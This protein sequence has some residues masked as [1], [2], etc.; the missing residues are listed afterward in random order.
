MR[1]CTVD[2]ITFN[3]V[4]DPDGHPYVIEG[5][6]KNALKIFFE[7]EESRREYLGVTVECPGKDFQYNLNNPT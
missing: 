1:I 6:G 2:P 3:D 5:S 4:P 7:S